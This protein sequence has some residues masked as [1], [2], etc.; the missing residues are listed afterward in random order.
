MNS[1]SS[2]WGLAAMGLMLAVG[3]LS[4]V[5]SAQGTVTAGTATQVGP[6]APPLGGV[7]AALKGDA[8]AEVRQRAAWLLEFWGG[9]Q[10]HERFG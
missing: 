5:A 4:A 3:F 10:G 8:D 2:M 6:P 7:T 9:Q 1:H